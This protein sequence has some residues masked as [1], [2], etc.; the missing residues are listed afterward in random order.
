MN[1]GFWFVWLLLGKLDW[2]KGLLFI[3][4]EI[5]VCWLNN[6]SFFWGNNCSFFFSLFCPFTSL[7]NTDSFG[8]IVEEEKIGFWFSELIGILLVLLNKGIFSSFFCSSFV[9]KLIE[10]GGLLFVEISPKMSP[11]LDLSKI[12]GILFSWL[13]GFSALIS[14]SFFSIKF[15]NIDIFLLSI[16]FLEGLLLSFSFTFSLLSIL[17]NN[18]NW[19]FFKSVILLK[20]DLLSFLSLILFSILLAL[21]CSFFIL[22]LLSFPILFIL[23]KL[24]FKF[25]DSFSLDLL[26]CIIGFPSNFISLLLV[27]DKIDG[28]FWIE[29]YFNP[30]AF[31]IFNFLNS[32]SLFLFSISIWS[33]PSA[34]LFA[35]SL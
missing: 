6:P 9:P 12:G 20:G 23:L 15:P 11:I 25:L 2:N 28:F 14:V 32:S 22:L 29:T 10:D 35:F 16:I 13:F 3:E 8:F 5:V 24:K 26:F 17:S 21:F 27:L 31:L 33:L 19:G 34:I 4:D 7:K 18:L 1:N 30:V